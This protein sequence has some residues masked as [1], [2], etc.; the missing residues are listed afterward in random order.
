MLL[1]FLCGGLFTIY[2]HVMA[3][4]TLCITSIKAH[5]KLYDTH[6]YMKLKMKQSIQMPENWREISSN[7]LEKVMPC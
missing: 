2:K 4:K 1:V 5:I 3:G 7:A 6:I